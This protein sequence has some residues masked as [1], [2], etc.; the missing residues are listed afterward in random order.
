MEVR[1]AAFVI[2]AALVTAAA[3]AG[4]WL[5]VRQNRADA[6][7]GHLSAAPGAVPAAAAALAASTAPKRAATD[8]PAAASEPD[9]GLVRDREA[10]TEPESAVASAMNPTVS[11]AP[12][13]GAADGGAVP[14]AE[15]TA[16][17]P[18]P[19]VEDSPPAPPTAGAAQR[20][21]PG[22]TQPA[23]AAP[24]V[25][26]ADDARG[27]AT[28][29]LPPVAGWV[30]RTDNAVRADEGP[31]PVERLVIAAEA[32]IGLQ[33][34]TGVSSADARVED[35]VVA[36]V[37]RNVL[38]GGRTALPAGTRVL[39]SVVLVEQAGKLRGS[40]RLGV[41]FHTAVTDDGS[42]VPLATDAVYREG[43]GR[44]SGST[45]RIG[46]GAVGGAILGAIF[47]GKRGAAIGSAAGAAGGT[48]LAMAGD[49]PPA[50]FQA[51]AA[52]TIR[53]LNP[54]TVAVDRPRPDRR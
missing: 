8:Q 44:G 34:E 48:A 32:V 50:T 3:G 10:E 39:G 24:T 30:R 54:A 4:G 40:P 41:R 11:D 49:G 53:L 33:L 20:E 9:H 17:L 42:E 45:Q 6:A 29:D 31:P 38:A 36:R 52:V 1:P 47:G 43:P 18:A 35:D 23:G 13:G 5:A 28:S 12:E 22:D 2:L 25:A 46:G 26:A 27:A 21:T 51:G 7:S 15:N 19:P 14:A 16:V 37:A